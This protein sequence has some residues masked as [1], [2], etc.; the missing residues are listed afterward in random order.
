M[1]PAESHLVNAL[2]S[3]LL[4]LMPAALAKMEPGMWT[5][6]F[7]S[8]NDGR[9]HTVL[10]G[11]VAQ[12]RMLPQPIGQRTPEL[13]IAET[14]TVTITP[15]RYSAKSRFDGKTLAEVEAAK[16]GSLPQKCLDWA[17][18]ERRTKDL[19]A[20]VHLRSTATGYD[21]KA[22]YATDHPQQSKAQTGGPFS[23]TNETAAALTDATMKAFLTQFEETNAFDENGERITWKMTDVVCTT[24]AD[25]YEALTILKSAGRAGVANNDVNAIQIA[26]QGLQVW[27]WRELTPAT[28]T[29]RYV[30]GFNSRAG[31]NGFKFQ[32]QKS[33]MPRAWFDDDAEEVLMKASFSGA[34]GTTNFRNTNRMKT[35]A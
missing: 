17:A 11:M 9:D 25:Y 20:T 15:V 12:G 8:F 13:A 31:E 30:H 26:N 16:N 28:G 5:R 10:S 34:F 2:N 24:Q 33:L 18:L 19:A 22:L 32:N 35:V 23:N 29:A 7:E 27:L 3:A 1:L 21:G 14:G 4:E 6:F